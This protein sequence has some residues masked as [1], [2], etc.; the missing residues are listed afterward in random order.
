MVD[1]GHRIVI[2]GGGSAGITVAARLRRK[3]QQ[4]VAVIEPAATH[5]YQ[6]LWTLVGGG[7]A[8][9]EATARP[10]STVMPKGVTWIRQAAVGVDPEARTVA[11]DDGSTVEYDKLVMCPG[12]QL[13]WE[14]I[15]GLRQTLGRDGVSS[16]YLYELAPATW[17]FIR[18]LR[19]GTA[20]FTMPS[21]P[22]KCAGAPQKIAYL[23]AD[24]W[25]E[26]GVLDKIDIHLVL[27]DPGHVRGEGVRRR[28]R[29]DGAPL[30][31]H[32]APPERS[33]RREPR[34]ARGH[35]RRQRRRDHRHPR[36][37][38][39]ARG[40]A[41]ERAGLGQEDPARRPHQPGRLRRGRQAHP[42]TRPLPRRVRPR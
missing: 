19:S 26:Q 40:P 24:Y 11:L 37:R 34:C 28:A 15:T 7:R 20:V 33:R 4:H 31:H 13:D 30:R 22:I 10:E 17:R 1:T 42:P 25:R 9:V 18:E 23:A 38:P 6:P 12:I 8:P 21:G 3:G 41:A 32:R 2:V 36:L 16:N 39:D 14:K 5:Y 29:A 35:H 27:P